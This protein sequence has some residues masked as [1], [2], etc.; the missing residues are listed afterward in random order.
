ML[1]NKKIKSIQAKIKMLTNELEEAKAKAESEFE[2]RETL[3][4]QIAPLLY[5]E[6]AW[7]DLKLSIDLIRPPKEVKTLSL[8]GALYFVKDN[9]L[10][11]FL[12]D[13]FM[14][15]EELKKRVGNASKENKVWAGE[16]FIRAVKLR[17]AIIHETEDRMLSY[18]HRLK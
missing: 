6:D 13:S 18:G 15:I 1:N 10:I 17:E 12:D 7:E 4:N 8:E 3:E 11:S 16:A 9:H 5:G 2:Y 14:I